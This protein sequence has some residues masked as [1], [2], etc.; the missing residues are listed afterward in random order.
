MKE[1]SKIYIAGHKGFAGSAIWENLH[2]RGYTNLVGR[3]HSELD[4]MERHSV[5]YFFDKEK[6]EYV[7]M[8]AAFTGKTVAN[9]NNSCRADFIYRNL[10]I[11]NNVIG[12]SFLHKVKK[13]LFLGNS[14]IYPKVS[15]QP[16]SEEDLLTSLPE[17]AD[18]PFA[19]A[20][21]AGIR[22][23]ESFNIQYR[24]NYISVVPA[25]F[26]GPNDNFNLEKCHVLPGLMRKMHLAKCLQE[27][28]WSGIQ[29][30]IRRRTLDDIGGDSTMDDFVFTLSKLGIYSNHLEIWGTGKP[31][32]EFLWSED[33]A[34]ACVYI[35]ENINF[36]ELKKGKMEVRNCHIN[37]G[38]GRETSIK[39][40]AFLMADILG[41]SGRIKFDTT[42]PD[43]SM[44]K[45]TD[46]SKLRS[47]GWQY[48]V[49]LDEGIRK[50]YE[51]YL[52]D[53]KFE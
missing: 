6:P 14:C 19:I 35:M 23:C 28:N 15:P 50:L 13:L 29:K 31:M 45:L 37:I 47:L 46:V 16:L 38:T 18:E 27:N 8:A 51:W 20:K 4:L 36:N 21:I 52:K 17:Y 49:D 30:D 40:L 12:E 10:Q 1:S 39:S 48:K 43:G 5:K 9:N 41:Y 24:T 11:Q 42:V 22:M 25:D 32:R 7:I 44:R 34:D 3:S 33:L 26:Y 53:Q 2:S